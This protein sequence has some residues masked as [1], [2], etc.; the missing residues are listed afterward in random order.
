[1]LTLLTIMGLGFSVIALLGLIVWFFYFLTGSIEASIG[2]T[3]M[4]MF[5]L[6]VILVIGVLTS[7]LLGIN[8]SL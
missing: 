6:G 8:I 5:G 3:M 4:L 1:M 7:L 2:F